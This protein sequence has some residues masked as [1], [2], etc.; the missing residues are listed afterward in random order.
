MT[1]LHLHK[2]IFWVMTALQTQGLPLMNL[3]GSGEDLKSSKLWAAD[4]EGLRNS[5]SFETVFIEKD[6]EPIRTITL[7]N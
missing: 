4:E 2:V 5:T 1:K 3:Q 6:T 7:Q